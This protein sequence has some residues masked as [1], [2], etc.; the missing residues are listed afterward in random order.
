MILELLNFTQTSIKKKTH[1]QRLILFSEKNLLFET[2]GVKE[3]VLSQS[4]FNSSHLLLGMG[5]VT[6][7]FLFVIV[8][9][10]CKKSY[11]RRRIHIHSVSQAENNFHHGFEFHRQEGNQS[12]CDTVSR[13]METAHSPPQTKYDDINEILQTRRLFFSEQANVYDRANYL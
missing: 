9:Q 12:S 11:S 8:L 13:S 4:E 3:R 1:P 6:C 5:G 10:L 2:E 7:L